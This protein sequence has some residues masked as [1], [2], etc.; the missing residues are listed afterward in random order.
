MIIHFIVNFYETFVSVCN[1]NLKG[2]ITIHPVVL[3]DRTALDGTNDAEDLDWIM[4]RDHDE[5]DRMV[6]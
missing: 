3:V 4:E 1:K 2:D 6:R 5:E